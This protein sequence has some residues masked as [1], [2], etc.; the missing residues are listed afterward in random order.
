MAELIIFALMA[1]LL[2][3]FIIVSVFFYAA[4]PKKCKREA[5]GYDC[6]GRDCEC[7]N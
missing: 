3:W 1:V 7:R 2:F 4:Q 5:G 6:K